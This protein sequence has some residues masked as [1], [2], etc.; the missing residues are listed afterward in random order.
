[1][2]PQ[3]K[4]LNDYPFIK[5]L[6]W[7]FC[8]IVLLFLSLPS[9][10][11]VLWA[12]RGTSTVGELGEFTSMW[13]AQMFLGSTTWWISFGYSLL[14]AIVAS[15]CATILALLYF[16]FSLQYHGAYQALGFILSL[17]PIVFPSIVYALALKTTCTSIGFPEWATLT[18]GHIV[19]LIPILYFLIESSNE[20]LNI[21]WIHSAAT[22][23]SSHRE[24]LR[25]IVFPILKRP[26]LVTF[27]IGLLFSFDEIVIASI[28]I[29]SANSTVPKRMWDAINRNMDP[30][31]A[32]VATIILF[33]SLIIIIAFNRRTLLRWRSKSI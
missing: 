23:G 19:L 21:E 28:V 33:L 9:L 5:Y 29:D 6:L 15:A 1:M 14:I 32:V 2:E 3:F 24:I 13:F 30:T 11:V 12:L 18:L 27:G 17:G 26:I 7:F 25:E 10:Y 16:Y 31:P 22:M 8:T 20:L 4:S